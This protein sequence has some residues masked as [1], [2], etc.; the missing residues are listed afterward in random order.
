M[1]HNKFL[2]GGEKRMFRVHTHVGGSPT[3]MIA[4]GIADGLGDAEVLSVRTMR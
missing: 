2:V 3:G 4:Q 1:M